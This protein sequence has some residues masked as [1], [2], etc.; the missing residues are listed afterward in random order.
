MLAGV[1][2]VVEVLPSTAVYIYT[3]NECTLVC[4]LSAVATYRMQSSECLEHT[5][6]P[7]LPNKARVVETVG[8][9]FSVTLYKTS[10]LFRFRDGRGT[11]VLAVTFS[12]D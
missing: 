12:L 10:S 5:Q 6:K 8:E 2:G 9:L 4:C 7:Q 11:V 1:A 3:I